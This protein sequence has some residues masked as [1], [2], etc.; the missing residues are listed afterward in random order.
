RHWA[1]DEVLLVESVAAQ[2]TT[3]IAQAELF[4]IVARAKNEWE[5]TFDAMS[6]GVFIFDPNGLLIRVNT[7]GASMDN[8]APQALLGRKCCEILRADT[9]ELECVVE[10]SLREAEPVNL[11]IVPHKL[12][13]PVLVTVEPVFDV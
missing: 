4:Q 2:L 7:A 10:R 12:K 1:E 6:D 3:G 13:R 8:A 5:T 11:E 9:D